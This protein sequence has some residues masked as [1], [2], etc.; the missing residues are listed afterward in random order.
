MMRTEAE[1]LYHDNIRLAYYILNISYPTF[2]KDEDMQQEALLGLWKACTTYNPDKAQFSTYA[3]YCILN[4]LRLAMR[5]WEKQPDTVSLNTPISDNEELTLGDTIEDPSSDID[6]GY[7]A[8]KLFI[9]GLPERERQLVRLMMNGLSQKQAA[10]KLGLSQWWACYALK[11]LRNK[12][13]KQE[14]QA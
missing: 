9:D 2:A 4:Q 6:E 8:L 5:G 7:M 10:N 1:Q 11:R 3:G 13:L 14:D 12:Y